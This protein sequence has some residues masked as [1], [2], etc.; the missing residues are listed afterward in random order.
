MND[1]IFPM[2]K[3]HDYDE[4]VARLAA[5]ANKYVDDIAVPI[6]VAARELWE[7]RAV[8]TLVY[9]WYD[10]KMGYEHA[11]THYLE[12]LADYDPEYPPFLCGEWHKDEARAFNDALHAL[13]I[14]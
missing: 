13:L 8:V 12:C 9:K 3:E 5:Y 6:M 10:A 14:R 4:F 11:R 2:T 1:G 7:D